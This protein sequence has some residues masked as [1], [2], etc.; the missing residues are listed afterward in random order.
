MPENKNPKN[1]QK[2][3]TLSPS[4]NN[5]YIENNIEFFEL[6]FGLWEKKLLILSSVFIFT[7]V[8][9]IYASKLTHLGQKHMQR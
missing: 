8:S 4:N 5:I 3:N 2:N 9:L 6:F 7:I 1:T